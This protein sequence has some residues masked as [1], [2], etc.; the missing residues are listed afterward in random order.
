M[1]LATSKVADFD[2]FLQTFSTR[3]AEK[4]REYGCKGSSVFRDPDDASRVFVVFDWDPD[5][6]R[7]FLAD[8]D[9]PGIFATAGLQQQPRVI[10]AAAAQD[11]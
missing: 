9:V 1:I 8:P 5:G 4:R 2:Q 7:K 3:G 11:S 10:E 6:W